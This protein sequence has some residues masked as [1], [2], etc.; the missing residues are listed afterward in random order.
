MNQPLPLKTVMEATAWQ[1]W[2]QEISEECGWECFL[3]V[4]QWL[5]MGTS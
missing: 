1:Q 5:L 2:Q 4:H 3:C